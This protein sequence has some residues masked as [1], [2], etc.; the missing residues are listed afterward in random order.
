[1]TGSAY[2]LFKSQEVF[3]KT[4]SGFKPSSTVNKKNSSPPQTTVTT[5]PCRSKSDEGLA[6]PGLQPMAEIIQHSDLQAHDY[7]SSL[8]C[9]VLQLSTDN[10]TLHRLLWSLK[11]LSKYPDFWIHEMRL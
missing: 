4:S 11:S 10:Q 2:R 1:M 9:A 7:W 3:Q 5:V 6:R 8:L